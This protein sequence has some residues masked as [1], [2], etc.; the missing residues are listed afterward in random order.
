MMNGSERGNGAPTR[1]PVS[2]RLTR[3]PSEGFTVVKFMSYVHGILTH[4]PRSASMPCPGSDLCPKG[5]HL[6]KTVWKGYAAVLVWREQPFADWTPSVLEL[7]E[8]LDAFL[9]PNSRVGEVWKLFRELG[10]SKHKEAMGE[11]LET[12]QCDVVQG[13][14]WIQPCLYKVYGTPF[15]KFDVGN[16]KRFDDAFMPVDDARPAGIAEPAPEVKGFSAAEWK[17][18]KM[19]DEK[20][21]KERGEV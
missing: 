19:E 13:L 12:R 4:R 11:Y 14:T 10:T 3:I 20:R 15:I 18:L 6:S 1:L 8:Q 9:G 2:L 17:R 21:R 5:T 7:T 16:P